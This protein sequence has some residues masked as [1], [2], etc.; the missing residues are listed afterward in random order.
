[1]SKRKGPRHSTNTKPLEPR[2]SSSIRAIRRIWKLL[3]GIAVVL[4]ILGVVTFLPR[5][6]VSIPDVVAD[7]R[8]PFASPFSVKND[9]YFPIYS[10]GLQCYVGQITFLHGRGGLRDF[11][12]SGIRGTDLT[13]NKLSA[14]DSADFKCLRLFEFQDDVNTADITVSVYFSVYFLATLVPKH[15]CVK[16]FGFSTRTDH[17]GKLHWLRRPSMCPK[18]AHGPQ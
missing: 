12:Y 3:A 2:R 17:E 18:M 16:C 4:T 11:T 6:S 10:I 8:D 7:N 1:M 9:G 13:V 15:F 5:I 14:G